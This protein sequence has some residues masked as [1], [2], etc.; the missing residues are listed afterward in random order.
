LDTTHRLIEPKQYLG[1]EAQVD[2]R[3][4]LAREMSDALDADLMQ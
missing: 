4:G 3:S 2:A 1:A